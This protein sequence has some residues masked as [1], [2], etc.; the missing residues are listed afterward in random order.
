MFCPKCS[1]LQASDHMRYCS[2]CGFPLAT[3]AHLLAHDGVLASSGKGLLSPRDKGVR[4][5][6]QLIFASLLIGFFTALLSV[7]VIGHPELFV[8][9]TSGVLFL[10]GI[11]RIVYA[12]MFEQVVQGQASP[13]QRAELDTSAGDYKLSPAQ[14]RFVPGLDTRRV[15][16]AEM[17]N[18]PSVTE[19][20]TKLLN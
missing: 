8:P 2:R 13:T 10:S 1:Q 20:T 14:T 7:F 15:N 6:V 11:L 3:V 5:G 18:S 17:I 4:H 9:L 12:Y 16:T 19:H